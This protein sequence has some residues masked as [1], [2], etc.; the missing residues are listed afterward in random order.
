MAESRKW[1]V[2]ANLVG[3]AAAVAGVFLARHA[4]QGNAERLKAAEAAKQEAAA[5]E[6]PAAAGLP[7]AAPEQA[8]ASAPQAPA[9][10]PAP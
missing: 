5:A 4:L 2:L 7:T 10:A 6:R 1:V 8:P 9:P 3:L